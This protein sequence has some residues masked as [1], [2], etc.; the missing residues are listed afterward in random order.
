MHYLLNKNLSFDE[1][2]LIALL[3]HLHEGG[4]KLTNETLK[5]YCEYCLTPIE[6]VS[7]LLRI[8]AFKYIEIT[9]NG[10]KYTIS[11]VREDNEIKE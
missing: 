5:H 10:D 7:L 3:L 9:N 11:I 8:R 4:I 6:I 1:K 2:G